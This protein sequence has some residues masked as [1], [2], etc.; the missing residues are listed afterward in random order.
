[1]YGRELDAYL[2]RTWKHSS[3][4]ELRPSITLIDTGYAADCCYDFI[5]PRQT[6]ARPRF[7]PAK[8]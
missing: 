3:G 6:A 7:L 4:A 5:L 2:L 8:G 1:M